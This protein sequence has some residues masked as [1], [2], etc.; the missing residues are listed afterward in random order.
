M[1]IMIAFKSSFKFLKESFIINWDTNSA[2]IGSRVIAFLGGFITNS[3]H[4]HI[5]I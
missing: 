4:L 3:V 2:R 5:I 1:E